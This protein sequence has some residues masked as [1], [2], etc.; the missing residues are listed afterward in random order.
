METKQRRPKQPKPDN[1]LDFQPSQAL[2]TARTEAT[3]INF[4]VKGKSKFE[5]V[6][7]YVALGNTLFNFGDFPFET[8]NEFGAFIRAKKAAH[9]IKAK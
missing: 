2:A 6:T 4:P 1:L 8:I 9:A 3:I 7:I 5:N